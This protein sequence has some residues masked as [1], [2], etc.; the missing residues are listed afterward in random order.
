MAAPRL[1][2]RWSLFLFAIAASLAVRAA[3]GQAPWTRWN[4]QARCQAHGHG[5]AGHPCGGCSV[6]A[7]VPQWQDAEPPVGGCQPAAPPRCSEPGWRADSWPNPQSCGPPSRFQRLPP[8]DPMPMPRPPQNF[9]PPSYTGGGP[10][11]RA[12]CPWDSSSCPDVPNCSNN[13]ACLQHSLPPARNYDSGYERGGVHSFISI[14]E[15]AAAR[16]IENATI[17]A[18]NSTNVCPTCRP[19]PPPSDPCAPPTAVAAAP[20]AIFWDENSQTYQTFDAQGGRQAVDLRQHAELQVRRDLVTGVTTTIDQAGNRV[21][22]DPS[23]VPLQGVWW[24]TTNG[25]LETADERGN[26]A[27]FGDPRAPGFRFQKLVE[28]FTI[29]LEEATKRVIMTHVQSGRSFTFDPR[30]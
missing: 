20:G 28:G 10:S 5:I 14:F 26:P 16:G 22:V 12:C 21:A 18:F 7:Q 8:V 4:S 13:D 1:R 24:S 11:P 2:L 30:P 23:S 6:P 3:S 27:A 19:Q 29:E 17:R 15:A 25:R 9:L